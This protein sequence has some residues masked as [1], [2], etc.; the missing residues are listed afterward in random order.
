VWWRTR[1]AGA[2]S[3]Q[4]AKKWRSTSVLM[5]L[6]LYRSKSAFVSFEFCKRPT[7]CQHSTVKRVNVHMA[8]K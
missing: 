4:N 8:E 3:L 2:R 1:K 6:I 7:T 5:W